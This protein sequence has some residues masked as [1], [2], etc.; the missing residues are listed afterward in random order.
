MTV[1]DPNFF[2]EATWNSKQFLGDW[3]EAP[4]GYLDVM[5]PASGKQ[6]S[7]VG[8]AGP[9]D[10]AVAATI[11]REAQ[12]EWAALPGEERAKVL[13]K[14]VALLAE[15]T[16]EFIPWIMRETGGIAPKAAVEVEHSQGFVQHAANMATEP[17]GLVLPSV[18]T[19]FS[20]VRRVPHGVVGVISPF[21]FPLIL[22]IRA[23]A[24]ALAAG[25][26]VILKPDPRTPI[27]GGVIIARVFEEAGLPK[28]LLHVL[29]GGGDVGAAMCADPNIAMISFTG[30][31]AAGRKVGEAAGRH[32]KKVQL[33]LGGKNSLIILDDADLDLAASCA[34]WGA[35]L[36]QGQI[37]IGSGRI[38]V[39]AGIADAIIEWLAGKATHLP[40]GDPMS[41]Q[42]ALGPL[43]DV[44]SAQRVHS[45]VQQSVAAGAKL[46]AGG[47]HDGAFY[48]PT[49]LTGLKKGMRAFDEEIFGP[50][51]CIATFGTDEEAVAMANDTDFGLSAGII[52]KSI[53][54]ARAIGDRLNVGHLHINDV[55]AAAEPYATFGGRGASGNGGRI[56]GP[57]NWE[58]FTQWQWV[59]MRDTP[60]QYPF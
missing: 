29:F 21:N 55:T 1:Q 19:H 45:I 10:V 52:S 18:G 6:L 50:V 60:V 7:R 37:C 57:A 12:P 59:T 25:N 27:S 38:L 53:G 48:K 31:V 8:K 41:N 58:E 33:E 15:H 13:R 40:V 51:A 49:V 30:G 43:I 3:K 36:N 24:P 54:R 17:T 42:V 35:Y 20:M 34:A 5:E 46:A 14:A 16:Q 32:L 26:A 39:Q 2:A 4:G 11:A 44:A 9:A 47:S 22:S 56:S 28:G 23:V